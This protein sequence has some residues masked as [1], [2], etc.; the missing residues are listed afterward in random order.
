MLH[1][2][3]GAHV[4]PCLWQLEAGN[5][6]MPHDRRID[7]KK[8]FIYRTECYSA[9]RNVNILS[10]VGKWVELENIIL[11]E[12]VQT[13]KDSHGM[14]SLISGCQKKK[15]RIL[16]IQSTEMKNLNKVKGPSVHASVLLR[17]QKKAITR[18]RKG[19]TLEGK[20]TG[21]GERGNMLWY[22]P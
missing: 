16:N 12:V 13:Q 18:E 10:F 4:Q 22:W 11:S 14:Y 19:G 2:T 20:W 9:I 21:S 17:Q 7:T 6:Q 1:H 8:W 3:T 5:T 15:Y